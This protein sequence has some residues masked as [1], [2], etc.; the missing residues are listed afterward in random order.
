MSNSQLLVDTVMSTYIQLN[1]FEQSMQVGHILILPE[2]QHTYYLQIKS[3]I[4]HINIDG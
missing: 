2:P 3:D 4:E 1:N